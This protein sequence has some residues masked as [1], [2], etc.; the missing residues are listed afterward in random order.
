M[1]RYWIRLSGHDGHEVIAANASKAK[2]QTYRHWRDAGYGLSPWRCGS[3]YFRQY[4]SALEVC[5]ALGEATGDPRT[6]EYGVAT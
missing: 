1:R 2:A 6:P 3:S 4:L 5:H